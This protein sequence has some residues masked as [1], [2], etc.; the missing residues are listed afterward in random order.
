M[1]IVIVGQQWLACELLRLAQRRGDIVVAVIAPT[2]DRLQAAAED[3]GVPVITCGRKVSEADIP[4]GTDIIL[5]AHA[6]VFIDASARAAARYGALG[7]HP[8]L[9]PRHRG[10]D[11]IR[12]ALHMREA[13][14]GGTVY[15]MDD[16]ADTGP[17]A[18]Q[19]WCHI[20]PDDDAR[21]LWRRE[22][23][24]IG[25]A[26]FGRVLAELDAG[27]VTARPQP[28]AVASWEP[29]FSRRQLSEA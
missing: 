11:A 5:A 20:R 19:E 7:Y 16:G 14:T 1:R 17:I 2:S 13:V 15:W 8:S 22:L 21:S 6:H 28:T 9:L 25:L 12:W 26:L 27:I 23:A 4:A 24:P 29:A 3:S 18:A 10:R